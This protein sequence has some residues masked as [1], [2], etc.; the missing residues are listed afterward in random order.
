M[1][2]RWEVEKA[3]CWSELEPPARLIMLALLTK[4]GNETAVVKPEHAPSLTTLA[5]MTGLSQSSVKDWLN[6]LEDAGWIKRHRRQKGN[7]AERTSYT[8]LIGSPTA[9]KRPRTANA[10]DDGRPSGGLGHEV[11]YPDRPSD[12]L[13]V[14]RQMGF[15]RPPDGPATTK[16]SYQKPSLTAAAVNAPP[17]PV[18]ETREERSSKD[19]N[20][21]LPHRLMAERYDLTGADADRVIAAIVAEHNPKGPAWWR[22]VA[23]NG[24]LD[25]IVANARAQADEDRT[26]R[27]EKLIAD[28]RKNGPHCYDHASVND[29]IVAPVPGGKFLHPTHGSPLCPHCR[30]GQPPFRRAEEA[31]AA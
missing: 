1:T 24:D 9:K 12:G 18:A 31:A 25:D 28:A 20:Q 27:N 6:A 7:R 16:T 3:V 4:S 10:D 19:Q 5:A 17:A 23:D 14:G 2:T 22:H 29:L 21:D 30:R 8:L 15:G 11:A 13:G 26:V